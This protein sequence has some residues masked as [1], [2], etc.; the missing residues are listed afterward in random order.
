MYLKH[1]QV[2]ILLIQV[3]YNLDVMFSINRT[4]RKSALTRA[5]RANIAKEHQDQMN[6]W[7]TVENSQGRR[8]RFNMR[9]HYSEAVLL[10]PTTW[11]YSYVL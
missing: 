2:E 3:D 7:R 5:V 9:Q 4:S 10:M 11:F 8:P 1:V 6:R